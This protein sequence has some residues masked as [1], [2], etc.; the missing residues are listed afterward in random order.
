VPVELADELACVAAWL[1]RNARKV[2]LVH[3]EGTLAS[4]LP[5]VPEL[6]LRR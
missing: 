4:A 6:S 1:D 5:A 3:C 2:R